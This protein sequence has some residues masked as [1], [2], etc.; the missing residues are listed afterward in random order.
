[1]RLCMKANDWDP[2][3]HP[4][5]VSCQGTAIALKKRRGKNE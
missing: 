3:V 5:L 1:M 2:K 4:G